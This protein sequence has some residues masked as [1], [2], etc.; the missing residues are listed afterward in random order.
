VLRFVEDLT[1]RERGLGEIFFTG[2]VAVLM[3]NIRSL[4]ESF[5]F[6]LRKSSELWQPAVESSSVL[7]DEDVG[8]WHKL[9]DIRSADASEID[10]K[11]VIRNMLAVSW[12]IEC[13]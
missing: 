13:G 6:C 2:I 3:I 12:K 8:E 9:R 4:S 5:P 10:R 1:N 7:F 11:E